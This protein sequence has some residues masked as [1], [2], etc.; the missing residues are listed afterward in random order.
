MIYE[1]EEQ[2]QII[3][4]IIEDITLT[5]LYHIIANQSC[6]EMNPNYITTTTIVEDNSNHSIDYN[7]QSKVVNSY[8]KLS[9]DN[10]KHISQLENKIDLKEIK[11]DDSKYSNNTSTTI[12]NNSN[13]N[14]SNMKTCISMN[15]ES[16]KDTYD[17]KDISPPPSEYNHLEGVI[18]LYPIELLKKK[19]KIYSQTLTIEELTM[20]DKL[21]I[22]IKKLSRIE[23]MHLQTM[24]NYLI[25]YDDKYFELVYSFMNHENLKKLKYDKEST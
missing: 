2:V 14:N 6:K 15:K 10:M 22:K 11:L 17:E 4:D 5:E 23:Q 9:K 7:S 18:T 13:S 25:S 8:H 21:K 12:N 3:S 20:N 1:Q 19:I 16:Y 24:F